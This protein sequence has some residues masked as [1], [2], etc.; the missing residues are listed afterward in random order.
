M[1]LPQSTVTLL[2]IFDEVDQASRAVSAI[3]GQGIGFAIPINLARN[4]M[5]QLK[6]K[7]SVT[8]G[9]LGVQIQA[10]TPELA[11]SLGLDEARGALVAGVFKGDPADKAGIEVGDVVVEFDGAPVESD[12]DLVAR[13]GNAVVGSTVAVKVVRSGREMS[14]DV[15]LA[16]RSDDGEAAAGEDSDPI[17][18]LK[19]GITVQDLTKELAERIRVEI[20]GGVLVTEVESGSSA[21]KAGIQRGDIIVEVNREKVERIDDFRAVLKKVRKDEKLLFLVQRGQ[22]NRFI[23]VTPEKEKD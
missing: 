13:V 21:D 11:E 19:L 20:D 3:I 5:D 12:R 4:I 2:A 8:R 10:I 23:V 16:R 6:E 14:F 17:Q 22:G 18:P 15:E 7:G 1:D 9:W